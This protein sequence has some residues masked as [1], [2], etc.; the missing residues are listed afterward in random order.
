MG[1]LWQKA[2][3]YLGLVDEEQ[4][5]QDMEA[6]PAGAN[7]AR[8]AA[9]P[10]HQPERLV[11]RRVEPPPVTRRLDPNAAPGPRIIH[12]TAAGSAGVR[13][14]TPIADA[15]CDVIRVE[16]FNDAKVLADR[17][18]DRVPVVLDLRETDPTMVRRLVDF[19]S[20]LIYALDGTMSKTAEGVILVLPPR[21]TVSMDERRRL[22]MLGLVADENR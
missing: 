10:E 22:G 9:P 14:V 21:V 13:P 8:A 17:I 20:G 15:Q 6:R 7:A 3:V 5:E 11:G 19:A 1:S 18:R 12:D 16:E 2:L 4:V